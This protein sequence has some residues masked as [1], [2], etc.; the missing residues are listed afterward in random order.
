MVIKSE[1][2]EKMISEK[3]RGGK[4]TIINNR[5]RDT[6]RCYDLKKCKIIVCF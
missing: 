4:G 3:P 6:L 2:A 5:Y 1:K